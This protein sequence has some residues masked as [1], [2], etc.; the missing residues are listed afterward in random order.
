[1]QKSSILK[2]SILV[3]A[4]VL[5]SA[6][7]WRIASGSQTETW[8]RIGYLGSFALGFIGAVSVIVPFPT[9]IALLGMAAS[10]QFD[11]ILLALSFGIGAAIGQLSSYAVGYFGRSV[12]DKKYSAKFDAIQRILTKHGHG[13]LLVFIFALTP[14]PDSII[15]IP[16]GIVRYS[17]WRV[18]ISALAGKIMMSLIITYFGGAV[19][20]VITENP[21]FTIATVILLVLAL[22]AMFKIDWEKFLDKRLHERKK[23]K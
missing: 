4:L 1:M 20:V 5:I 21:V 23:R 8:T 22:V 9:T 11:L 2:I 17:L 19:G 18:F 6:V 3:G 15:F 10:Q 13:M 7:F 12:I 14:L 16:L